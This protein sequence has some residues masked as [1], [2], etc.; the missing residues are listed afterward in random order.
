M[1]HWTQEQYQE[2]LARIGAKKKA[3]LENGKDTPDVGPELKLA[4]KIMKWAKEHGYPCQ[5]FRQSRKAK[6]FL[7]PGWP[8]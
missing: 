8:D 2:Y 4:G 5:C 6:S 1:T 7:V 3:F